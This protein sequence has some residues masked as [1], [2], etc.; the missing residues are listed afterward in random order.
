MLARDSEYNP[1]SCNPPAFKLKTTLTTSALILLGVAHSSAANTSEFAASLVIDTSV[2]SAAGQ[3][4]HIVSRGLLDVGYETSMD[5][6]TFFISGQAQRGENG[7]DYIG[8]IQAFSNIDEDDFEKLYEAWLQYEF[9]DIGT[10]VK[11]GQMDVNGEFA[12]ADNA[13]EFINSSM[14]FSPTVFTLPTYPDPALG[15]MLAQSISDSNEMAFAVHAGAD[16]E[17]F[18]DLFYI[19]EWRYMGDGFNA[20]IGGWHH[21]GDFERL[22]DGSIDSGVQGYYLLAEGQFSENGW[23]YYLQFAGS[24]EDVSEISCHF[25]V[26]VTTENIGIADTMMGIGVSMVRLSDWLETEENTEVAW[27]AFLRYEYSDHV[28]IKPDIQYIASPSGES[29]NEFV[30]T[31]RLELS[32]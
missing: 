28:A 3:D 6:F 1:S 11:I 29:R 17:D 9:S 12:F 10:R 23:G 4:K 14:G 22:S 16:N 13:G 7:S 18:D 31:L 19:A 2:F 24:D 5:N 32:Y 26:G 30:A 25:G 8:D 20:K 27:E 21:D 15:F